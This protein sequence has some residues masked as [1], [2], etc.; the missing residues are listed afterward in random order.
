M[1]LR[2]AMCAGRCTGVCVRVRACTRA[3]STHSCMCTWVSAF[4]TTGRA[5]ASGEQESV[6]VYVSECESALSQ[7]SVLFIWTAL[8]Q[9]SVRISS[10]AQLEALKARPSVISVFMDYTFPTV[11]GLP[12]ERVAVLV[13]RIPSLLNMMRYCRKEGIVV[14]QVTVES[15]V[16]KE[17]F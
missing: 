7:V 8:L 1:C 2:A 10:D 15:V 6:V 3:L 13:V 4:T 5:R 17:I 11:A 9:V 12:G 16:D 14:R